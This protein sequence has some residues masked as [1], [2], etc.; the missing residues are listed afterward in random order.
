MSQSKCRIFS[1]TIS[2]ER[3]DK[4]AGFLYVDTNSH[5]LKV[6]QNIFGWAW[7]K[8]GIASLAATL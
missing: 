2:P 5:K 1:S 6:D 7:S 8:M 3:V 4:I